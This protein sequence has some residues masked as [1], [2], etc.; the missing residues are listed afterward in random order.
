[1]VWQTFCTSLGVTFA[2]VCILYKNAVFVKF[3]TATFGHFWFCIRHCFICRLSD[4][5]VLEGCTDCVQKNLP[6]LFRQ[7]FTWHM[8]FT[9]LY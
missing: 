8:L 3:S 7:F 6:S 4:S 1:M 5:T 9:P 2:T